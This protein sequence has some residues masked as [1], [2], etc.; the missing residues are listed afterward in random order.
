MGEPLK[1]ACREKGEATRR[2]KQK[3]E[4]GVGRALGSQHFS[5]YTGHG[6]SS[7]LGSSVSKFSFLAPSG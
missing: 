7:I 1:W 2:L 3:S 6:G 5:S 4:T